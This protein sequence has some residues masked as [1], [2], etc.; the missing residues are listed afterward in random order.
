VPDDPNNP[1]PA[2]SGQSPE[3]QAQATNNERRN[4]FVNDIAG[5]TVGPMVDSRGLIRAGVIRDATQFQPPPGGGIITG[6]ADENGIRKAL[7]VV[8]TDQ[9]MA[10]AQ[11][12][13]LGQG[14]GNGPRDVFGNDM[15]RTLDMQRQIDN[16][17][18][19]RAYTD[20]QSLD[21]RYVARGLREGAFYAQ[22]DAADARARGQQAAAQVEG[23]KLQRTI[24]QDQ[25]ADHK[26]STERIENQ[27]ALAAPVTAKEGDPERVKQIAYREGLSNAL[28]SA[29]GGKIPTNPHEFDHY[30]PSIIA[31]GKLL[32]RLNDA[33][34]NPGF[35]TGLKNIAHG[36]Y[37]GV[38]GSNFGGI[39]LDA[40]D[41]DNVVYNGYK[42][43]TKSFFANDFLSGADGDVINYYYKYLEAAKERKNSAQK[44]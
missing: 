28:Y 34:A 5:D 1:Q 21:P 24:E 36:K 2:Q 20:R 3:Q 12:G 7:G 6:E 4:N 13:T 37:S 18:R 35:L 23:A 8:P 32:M 9:E 29:F 17:R 33:A 30:L 39:D 25:R 15:T 41:K 10:Q 16:I 40:S 38:T 14:Q 31:G 27:L 11:A 22:N 44:Q 42:I 19:E 43:P 26:Q